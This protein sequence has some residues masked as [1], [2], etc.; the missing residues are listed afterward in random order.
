MSS[1]ESH[2]GIVKVTK[3]TAGLHPRLFKLWGAGAIVVL[4]GALMSMSGCASGSQGLPSNF[5]FPPSAGF[6]IVSAALP[7]GVAGRSYTYYVRLSGGTAPFNCSANLPA[8]L[9]IANGPTVPSGPLAGTNACVI[10]GT[11]TAAGLTMV[12]FTARDSSSPAQVATPVTLSLN[13]R[14]EF[15]VTAPPFATNDGVVGRDY[16][17]TTDNCNGVACASTVTTTV[18]ATVGNAP[19]TSCTFTGGTGGNTFPSPLTL[20][21]SN[22]NFM[23]TGALTAAGSF[24]LTF[25]AQDSPIVDPI[26]GLTVVFPAGTNGNPPVTNTSTLKVDA[27]LTIATGLPNPMDD[28][29]VNA[30]FPYDASPAYNMPA[31]RTVVATAGTGLPPT[32]T[33]YSCTST[34]FPAGLNGAPTATQGPP[35]TCAVS[36]T[37][38]AQVTG[39]AVSV[40]FADTGNHAVPGASPSGPPAATS[41]STI[42]INPQPTVTTTLTSPAD[43]GV[44]D[45]DTPGPN[46]A[47]P[48]P[49]GPIAINT[50]GGTGTLALTS[51]IS[52]A[53][54]CTGLTLPNVGPA[55]PA[56]PLPA[57]PAIAGSLGGT[58]TA[59]VT[60]PA[61]ATCTF[62]VMVTDTTGTTNAAGNMT[63]N[64]IIHAPLRVAA[65]V[66]ANGI[67]QRAFSQSL[68]VAISGGTG[69]TPYT[70]AVIGLPALGLSVTT[71]PTVGAGTTTPCT[72][73]I[74]GPTTNATAAVQS[75]LVQ[76]TATD[77]GTGAGGAT[78]AGTSPPNPANG[79]ANNLF[80]RPEFAFTGLPAAF[81]DGVVGRA[82]GTAAGTSPQVVNTNVTNTVNT[83]PGNAPLQACAFAVGTN[84]M[85]NP[86]VENP[87]GGPPATMCAL[88]STGNLTSATTAPPLAVSTPLS[89]TIT[90]TDSP[91]PDPANMGA[92]PP[93][94]PAPYTGCVVPGKLVTAGTAITLQVDPALALSIDAT[95]VDPPTFGVVNRTYGNTG[96]GFKALVYDVSGGLGTY[97]FNFTNAGTVTAPPAAGSF[98]VPKPVACT[99]SS[100]TMATCT[101]G[102]GLISATAGAYPFKISVTDAANAATPNGTSSN[103]TASISRTITIRNQLA[104]N[105]PQSP[106]PVPNA[107]TGRPYGTPQGAQDLIYSVSAG[108]GLPT[109][110]ISA[111]G[112]PTPIA[113]PTQNNA[114]DS[115]LSLHCTSGN[116]GV[117]GATGTGVVTVTDT[118]NA[119]TPAATVATD[120]NSVLSSA[121]NTQITVVPELTIGNTSVENATVGEPYSAIGYTNNGGIPAASPPAYTWSIASGGVAGVAFVNPSPPYLDDPTQARGYYVGTPTTASSPTITTTVTVSD[122][123]NPTTPSCVTVAT[124]PTAITTNKVFPEVGFVATFASGATEQGDT[125]VKFDSNAFASS[126]FISLNTDAGFDAFPVAARVTPDGEWVYVTKQGNTHDVSVVDS[127]STVHGC[128][129]SA[130][131]ATNDLAV[132]SIVVSNTGTFNP[133]ALDIEG[134]KFFATAF[135]CG[136]APCSVQRH[137]RYDLWVVDPTDGS[138]ATAIVEPIADAENPGLVTTPLSGANKVTVADANNIAIST[139]TTLAF[140]SVN[141]LPSGTACGVLPTN[142]ATLT[143]LNLPTTPI[144]AAPTTGTTQNTLGLRAGQ[145]SVDPRGNNVYTATRSQDGTIVYISVTTS[146]AAPSFVSY[147]PVTAGVGT[148]PTTNVCS[149]SGTIYTPV[150]AIP[151]AITASPDGNRLF[152]ACLDTA[153]PQ[154]NNTVGVWDIS[155]ATILFVTSIALPASSGTPV[156]AENGCTTPVDVK[157]RLTTNAYGTR[158]FVSCQDSDTIV[159]IEYNTGPGSTA[160]DSFTFDTV[161][162]TDGTAITN[163]S[164]GNTTAAYT[165]YACGNTGSCPQLLDLMPNP[166]IHFTTGGFAPTLP[167]ALAKATSGTPYATFIAVQGGTVVDSTG[168]VKRSWSETTPTGLILNTG[169]CA[170]LT[171][172]AATG[173]I[174]GTPTAASGSVC[175]PFTI[176]ATDASVVPVVTPAGQF[177]ERSFTIS[178]Q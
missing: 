65:F 178:I 41:N 93:T 48:R 134:Q 47:T 107:V 177:V 138:Q 31:R 141:Y 143:P 146:N 27:A 170:G 175:G 6:R 101:G 125:V 45:M 35:P 96:G 110:T 173:E 40:S 136:T 118:A 160:V 14:P 152:I 95:S 18:S 124:C 156:N 94:T 21:G 55:A 98:G 42:T 114:A 149:S 74:T 133:S 5:N 32:Q 162:S 16:G 56:V 176:R 17:V 52:G 30:A 137:F 111:V 46:P 62:T 144:G 104:V 164:I 121:A 115:T 130:T 15:M 108:E 75:A 163:A 38:T 117:T 49:Y 132:K 158:L 155:G 59:S 103:T 87:T 78:A 11:P 3:K 53:M 123:S 112:F 91:I 64:I 28:W 105:T 26:T 76:V 92:C 61:T 57:A 8:N 25:A 54:N 7:D 71:G 39:A 166:P 167:F 4:L 60:A 157:A 131:C 145:V 88:T 24:T 122:T 109:V 89:L 51:N 169:N 127:I 37:P 2:T 140:V 33:T 119:T 113:C 90:A 67:G 84:L 80:V 9:S 116:M 151:E 70:C 174:S 159:P 171:I 172:N 73:T 29:T 142:C 79:S 36:G 139:D 85:T 86:L 66:L 58:P 50:S 19:L 83:G 154:V 82:Y 165:N 1:S 128:M 97:T 102:A 106:N 77:T 120:P 10:T 99:M 168:A 126:N 34:G 43:D 13:I 161:F 81:P 63:E 150:A 68:S 135:A 12:T 69:I 153:T 23:S 148:Q 72:F 147:I 129:T 20:A 44:T 100:A 22:C